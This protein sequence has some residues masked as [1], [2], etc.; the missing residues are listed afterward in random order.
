MPFADASFDLVIANHV[1]EHVDDDRRALAEI[2]RVL[3]PE[4][5]AILQTPYSPVLARTWE[6]ANIRD[7]CARLQAFGQEDHVRLYGSDIFAR[8]E[9]AGLV[10]RVRTHTELLAQHDAYYNGVNARE[11]FF[12]FQRGP[13]IEHPDGF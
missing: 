7:E 9:S 3:A 6:D 10:S 4:G 8:F 11:P 2:V 5:R 12:L 13:A 1:L